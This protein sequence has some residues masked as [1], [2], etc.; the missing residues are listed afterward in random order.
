MDIK[1]LLDEDAFDPKKLFNEKEYSTLIINRD[2][3][4]KKENISADLIETLLDKA[5]TRTEAEDIFAKLKENNAKEL[6]VNAI[7]KAGRKSEKSIIAAA[8]W[9]SGLDFS[10]NFLFF[11]ELATD[12]DFQLAMEALT[13]VQECEGEISGETLKAAEKIAETASRKNE[14]LMND[15]LSNIRSRQQK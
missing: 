8:C 10:D 2:G 1:E 11:V 9:E 4:S 6:L 12:E 5:T 15:L 13:V 7:R 3:F 14:S